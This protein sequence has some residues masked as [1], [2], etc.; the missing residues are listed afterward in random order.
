VAR[1]L[2]IDDD[3]DVCEVLGRLLERDGHS[4]RAFQSGEDGLRAVGEDTYDLVIADIF[5]PQK[6]G[7]EV[8]HELSRSRPGLKIIAMTAF[9]AQDDVDMRSFSKRYGANGF[10]EKPFDH[11]KVRETVA[12]VLA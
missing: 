3:G 1:I 7:L 8:I 12:E 4:V 2:I 10:I 6:S 9:T 5:L 11:Q